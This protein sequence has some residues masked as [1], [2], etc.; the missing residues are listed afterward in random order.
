L[1]EEQQQLEAKA[2]VLCQKIIQEL[3]DKNRVKRETIN[4]IQSKVDELESQLNKLS[5]GVLERAD[6]ATSGSEE[7]HESAEKTEEKQQDGGEN[8]VIITTVDQEDEQHE[9]LNTEQERRKH[10]FF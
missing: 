6:V 5:G 9:N 7:K 4:Q 3:K 2:K 10:M 8:A 1:E